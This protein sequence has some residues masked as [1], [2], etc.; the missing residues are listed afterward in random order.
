MHRDSEKCR[1]DIYIVPAFIFRKLQKIYL[2]E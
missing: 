2:W 1:D